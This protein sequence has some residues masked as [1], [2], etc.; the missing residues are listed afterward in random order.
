MLDKR[1]EDT[2]IEDIK[3]LIGNDTAE[4]RRL[5]YKRQLNITSVEEKQ[6]FLRDVIAF[7]NSNGGDIIFGI[8]ENKNDAINYSIEGFDIDET[9]DQ[10]NQKIINIVR[11]STEP[12]LTNIHFKLIK[13]KDNKVIYIIRIPESILKPHRIT[14]HTDSGFYVRTATGKQKMDV[15]DLRIAFGFANDIR[16]RIANY[17]NNRVAAI[18]DELIAFYG[19]KR[20]SII[21]HAYP[22]SALGGNSRYTIN[23]LKY[24][25]DKAGIWNFNG[26]NGNRIV[27][28]GVQFGQ[29]HLDN[30][31]FGMLYLMNNGIIEARETSYFRSNW[32]DGYG[33]KYNGISY[34]ALFNEWKELIGKIF[35]Y[36]K[37]MEISFPIVF[38][39]QIIFAKN[40]EIQNQTMLLSGM[41]SPK[42]DRDLLNLTAVTIDNLDCSVETIL[43]PM[44]DSLW[45]ASGYNHCWL[46]DKNK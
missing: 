44:L 27:V 4:N 18:S 45:N 12:K 21:F 35:K 7:A 6:E 28:D 23:E 2:E 33:G 36:Y 11:D 39:A 40:Y 43:Q 22:F 16:T 13:Y 37:L 46:F 14:F 24:L 32:P 5:E 17:D 3:T 30:R 10:L 8:A 41:T 15:N 29:G 34:E 38:T 26:I 1:L 25:C 20:P 42:I 19:E 9:E 31:N